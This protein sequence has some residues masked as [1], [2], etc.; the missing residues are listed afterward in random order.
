VPFLGG[1]K[2]RY[3]N[4]NANVRVLLENGL[5][6]TR[7][8]GATVNGQEVPDQVLAEIQKNI[9]WEEIQQDP[10]VRELVNKIDWLKIEN[11]RVSLGRGEPGP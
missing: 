1:I 2:G 4:A 10:K 6:A 5:V 9:R 7:L 11:S 3:I 8:E